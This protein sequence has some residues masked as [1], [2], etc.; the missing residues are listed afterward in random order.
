MEYEYKN[1]K[2]NKKIKLSIDKNY[3]FIY[4][5]NGTGKT[6]F[7][8]SIGNGKIIKDKE[9][10]KIHLVFNQDFVNNNIYISTSDGTYKSDTKNKS[11]LKQIFLGDSSKDDN[12]KLI[13]LRQKIREYGKLDFNINNFKNDF[14]II[15]MDLI[16]KE[17]NYLKE[18]ENYILQYVDDTLIIKYFENILKKI[19]KN[20]VKIDS[21]QLNDEKYI[22]RIELG[23]IDKTYTEQEVKEELLKFYRECYNNKEKSLNIIVDNFNKKFINDFKIEILN[24]K[25]ESISEL[26]EKLKSSKELY[27]IILKLETEE[28]EYLKEILEGKNVDIKNVKR[29]ITNG[30]NFHK[31]IDF[32]SCLYCKNMISKELKENKLTLIKNKY[33]IY[34]TEYKK[35][36]DEL[37]SIIDNLENEYNNLTSKQVYTTVKRKKEEQYFRIIMKKKKAFK[38][39]YKKETEEKQYSFDVIKQL[40]AFINMIEKAKVYL[41]VVIQ[42]DKK[43]KEQLLKAY[44]LYLLSD[45][46]IKEIRIS[47]IKKQLIKDENKYKEKIQKD[48]Q[49]YISKIKDYIKEFENIYEPRFELVINTSLSRAD[50]A[51]TTIEITS[52]ETNFLNNISEGEKNILALIIFFSY[53]KNVLSSL[54]ENEQIVLIL[55]DP[56][57]SNDWGNFFKFQAIIEDY[58]YKDIIQ[59]KKISN[60]IILSHNI[61]Y[62]I[63]QLENDKYEK[64][65]EFI[66]L[67]SDKSMK[68]DTDFIF[69]DD[70]KLGSK[71][72]H[73][74]YA[75]IE[76]NE[77]KC[78]IEKHKLYRIAIYM[79]KF[80]ESFLNR[81]ITI[82][83]PNLVPNKNENIKFIK[84][85][86]DSKNIDNLL[87]VST[88][89]IK[90]SSRGVYSAN[91]YMKYLT[92]ALNDIIDNSNLFLQDSKL[93]VL[94]DKYKDDEYLFLIKDEEEQN[95]IG[96]TFEIEKNESFYD[97]ELID[98]MIKG[99]VT[100]IKENPNEE[101]IKYIKIKAKNNYLKYMRHINDNVG[102]P[103]LAVNS[104]N[105]I[106][107]EGEN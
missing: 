56:V 32:N 2:N 86:I 24:E 22:D 9:I 78:Y 6:T 88:T 60:V 106:D 72:I 63:I 39:K 79:R 19:E 51:E 59:D 18:Y 54:K 38:I 35:Q 107:S 99:L 26:L 27:E 70:I 36:I 95:I 68:I 61:D 13:F 33:L 98:I 62:A 14:K 48:T 30:D 82:A 31:E 75:N 66:R 93:R 20:E 16:S 21:L 69:M 46:F 64:H 34:L 43:E 12:E 42:E 105:I 57:N 103:V 90:D 50:N 44:Q 87:N 96:N 25:I 7:S 58:F 52:N 85:N 49:N 76:C 29:W 37:I 92:L 4:G 53:V 84:D 77:N 28:D 104:D 102:R 94:I 40:N 83:D 65:F 23:E 67:F 15:V 80:L 47:L 45:K 8:R 101:K 71:L 97:E 89:I 73:D 91:E 100:N 55:D 5:P 17:E 41:K 3:T 11:K 10:N 81:T 74:L 1:L